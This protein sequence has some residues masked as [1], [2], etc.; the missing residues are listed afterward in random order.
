M[1]SPE[2]LAIQSALCGLKAPIIVNLGA[3]HGEDHAVFLKAIDRAAVLTYIMV[4]P[5][6]NNC[7]TI[8]THVPLS[9]NVRLVEG[10]IYDAPGKRGFWR[11]RR[12]NTE[13]TG[14]GSL[15]KPSGHLK[16]IPDVVFTE[17]IEVECF[18]LDE[19]FDVRRLEHIDLLWVDI[20]GA[21][22][23]MIRG[24]QKA[25]KHTHYCFMEAEEVEL[26]EGQT[27]RPALI[28]LLPEWHL[29][30][31]FGPNILL[32]NGAYYHE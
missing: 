20:Q 10:A 12:I 15:L 3:Y 26:Y 30:G 8:R 32:Q 22:A 23:A 11:S 5:D 14:S 19:I 13:E 9:E 7:R 17:R 2:F 16:I 1:T 4:E 18:T 29:L 27:L 31:S 21:E 24:G 6:P 25:L 28:Y